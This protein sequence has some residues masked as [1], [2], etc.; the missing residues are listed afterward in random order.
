MRRL[1][2]V[3]L[4]I[5]AAGLALGSISTSLHTHRASTGV[6]MRQ[7][8]DAGSAI[9]MPDAV[10]TSV[11]S[12]DLPTA[13]TACGTHSSFIYTLTDGSSTVA[14]SGIL[15]CSFSNDDGV[16]TGTCVDSGESIDGT[17][18]GAACDA[19]SVTVVGAVATAKISFNNSLGVNGSLASFS[20]LNNSCA[21]FTRL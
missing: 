4:T 1:I 18:C 2:F 19:D 21:S 6:I 15:M 13:D 16:V 17:G 5:A 9:V 7:S 3:L 10:A 20:V 14:H 11:F 12:V 8:A